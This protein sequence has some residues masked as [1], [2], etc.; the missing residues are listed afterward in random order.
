MRRLSPG[1]DHTDESEDGDS[2]RELES[3]G[4]SYLHLVASSTVVDDKRR[5]ALREVK[6]SI[7]KCRWDLDK[8]TSV[9]SQVLE[10]IMGAANSGERTTEG[11]VS[12]G[13]HFE[14]YFTLKKVP[15]RRVKWL[16]EDGISTSVGRREASDN[17]YRF[18][19]CA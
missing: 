8:F 6:E 1:K 9:E 19:V 13:G 11:K 2:D 4:S 12:E 15:D 14:V 10:L 5:Q 3:E 16:F 7:D 18:C 17:I